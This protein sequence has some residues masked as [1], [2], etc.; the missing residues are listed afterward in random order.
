MLEMMV[1]WERLDVRKTRRY[2]LVV[3]MRKEGGY[4]GVLLQEAAERK[5]KEC[6]RDQTH[7]LAQGDVNMIYSF[8]GKS[9]TICGR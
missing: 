1:D 3:R 9:A 6:L 7:W 5:A 2:S 8:K 4:R